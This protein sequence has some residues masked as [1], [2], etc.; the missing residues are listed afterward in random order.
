MIAGQKNGAVAAS[1]AGK[2]KTALM[3]T[4]ITLI[5]FNDLPFSLM[6]IYPGKIIVMIATVLSILSGVGY[7]N[8]N[9]KYLIN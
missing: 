1:K 9:R 6:S 5:L 8:K 4:G 2:A 3:L 7:Y